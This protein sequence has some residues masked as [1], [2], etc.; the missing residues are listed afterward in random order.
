MR[1]AG[2]VTGSLFACLVGGAVVAQDKPADTMEIFR[3]KACL[4][5]CCHEGRQAAPEYREEHRSLAH[6]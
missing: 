1:S 3:E 5:A 6:R 4:G 2:V